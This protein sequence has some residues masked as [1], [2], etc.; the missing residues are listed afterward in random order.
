MGG[1]REEGEGKGH[2]IF[3]NKLLPL[4]FDIQYVLHMCFLHVAAKK[5]I[6]TGHRSNFP[7]V[8]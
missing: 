7:W 8:M 1:G 4:M 5:W 6:A 2:P 3:A